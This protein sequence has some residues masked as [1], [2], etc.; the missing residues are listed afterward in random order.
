MKTKFEQAAHDIQRRKKS[1]PSLP[2]TIETY[3][4]NNQDNLL[5]KFLIMGF[6]TVLGLILLLLIMAITN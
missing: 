6:A 4:G 2:H 3:Q 5:G 1:R